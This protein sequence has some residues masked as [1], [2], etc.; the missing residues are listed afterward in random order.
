MNLMELAVK[1]S[2]SYKL[3]P[4]THCIVIVSQ[5]D[6]EK[7]ITFGYASTVEKQTIRRYLRD[8]LKLLVTKKDTVH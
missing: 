8:F 5:Y 7:G 2:E 6:K 4:N 1:V 3:P